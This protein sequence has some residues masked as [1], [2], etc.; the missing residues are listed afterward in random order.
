TGSWGDAFAALSRAAVDSDLSADD[1]E[2]LARAALLVASPTEATAWL[3]RAHAAFL[4]EQRLPAAARAAFWLCIT[5][6]E[7]GGAP[8][9]AA[10]W[11]ATAARVLDACEEECAE[12]GYLRIPAGLRA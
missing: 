8:A 12:H 2:L 4:A 11:L 5:L 3:E 6:A 10:G 9:Q 7:R 1:L